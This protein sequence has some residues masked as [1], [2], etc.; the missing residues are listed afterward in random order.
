MD[1]GPALRI[2]AQSLKYLKLILDNMGYVY[3]PTGLVV[4]G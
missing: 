1:G 3:L 2:N 4:A